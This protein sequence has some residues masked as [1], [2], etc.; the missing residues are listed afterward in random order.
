MNPAKRSAMGARCFV[1]TSGWNY[2]HWSEGVFYPSGLKTS[3]WLNHY[4]QYF[5]SVEINNSFYRLPEKWV[6]KKWYET[7]PAKFIFAVKASRFITHMKKLADPQEH[8]PLFLENASALKE[9]LGVVLFQ[10]PPYWKFNRDR[11]E[12]LFDFLS[13]QQI[14]P[15]L[16]AALEIRHKSWQSNT[17]FDILIKYNISL[18]LTDWPG[19]PI[20]GPLTAEFVFM[21]RHGPGSLYASNYSDAHLKRDAQRIRTWLAQGKDV[22]IYFNNDAFGYAVKNAQTLKD[23]LAKEI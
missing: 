16:H 12:G 14:L 7:P 6:F 4:A 2:K 17:C 23:Y 10:L 11:L 9:K 5:D 3:E 13:R 19:L 20:E 15:G 1:G 21:R 8:L 18:A 22:Y